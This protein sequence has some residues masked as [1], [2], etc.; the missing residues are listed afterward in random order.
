MLLVMFNTQA[1]S[2]PATVQGHSGLWRISNCWGGYGGD[3]REDYIIRHTSENCLY[4]CK[5]STSKSTFLIMQV[6][7]IFM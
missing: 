5:K 6:G 4:V 1:T 7:A 2:V 3:W